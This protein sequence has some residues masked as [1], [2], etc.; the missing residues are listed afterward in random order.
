MEGNWSS[1][2]KALLRLISHMHPVIKPPK[3]NFKLKVD[4][5]SKGNLSAFG[6]GIIINENV[7]IVLSFSW[8]SGNSD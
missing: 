8:P 3:E 2:W 5:S 7:D 4:G 1:S 6:M